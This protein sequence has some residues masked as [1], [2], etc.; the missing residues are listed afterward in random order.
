MYEQTVRKCLESLTIV[1]FMILR[2]TRHNNLHTPPHIISLHSF[3]Y[4]Y[5]SLLSPITLQRSPLFSP[6]IVPPFHAFS[7]KAYYMP[8]L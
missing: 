3:F 7:P 4:I 1:C 2:E 5:Y 8:T 6:R